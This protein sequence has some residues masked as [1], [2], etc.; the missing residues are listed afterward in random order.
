MAVKDLNPRKLHIT[1]CKPLGSEPSEVHQKK[2]K[3]LPFTYRVYFVS[4]C[5][6]EHVPSHDAWN[7]DGHP[8]LIPPNPKSVR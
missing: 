5:S 3:N 1:V 2:C 8:G 4:I 6:G 7:H